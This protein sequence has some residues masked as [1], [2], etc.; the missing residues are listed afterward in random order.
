MAYI[1]FITEEGEFLLTEEQEDLILEE[2][3]SAVSVIES[4]DVPAPIIVENDGLTAEYYLRRYLNDNNRV[5]T[6][7]PVQNLDTVADPFL[8]TDYFRKY[9]NDKK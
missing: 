2:S 8:D 6:V 3:D 5:E 7:G 1:Q 9:L 4:L